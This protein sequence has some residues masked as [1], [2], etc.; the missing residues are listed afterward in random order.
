MH[1]EC[2]YRC[3]PEVWL[4]KMFPGTVFVSTDLPENRLK[5]IKKNQDLE[6]HDE[7]STDIFQ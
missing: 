7:H 6:Q 4:S 5:M 3:I 1:K 2:V